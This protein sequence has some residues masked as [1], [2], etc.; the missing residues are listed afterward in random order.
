MAQVASQL[1]RL[2]SPK[3][4]TLLEILI[5]ITILVVGI[6]GVAGLTIGIIKGNLASREVTTAVTLAQ[7]KLEDIKRLGYNNA[8]GGTEGYNSNADFPA[9]KRVTTITA[10]TPTTNMKKVT[11]TVSW[12]NDSHSLAVE[13]FLA[14]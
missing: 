4:F 14:Q 5:A 12:E 1:R 11:V 10:N 8:A 7:D 2:R 3:A 9:Y 6:L 13:T